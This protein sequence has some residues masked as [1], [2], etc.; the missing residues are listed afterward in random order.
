MFGAFAGGG[1]N[2]L[3]D[4]RGVLV[5]G[6]LL[7]RPRL[8]EHPHPMHGFRCGMLAPS[9]SGSTAW[10]SLAVR[11]VVA[12]ATARGLAEAYMCGQ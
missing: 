7:E 11:I 6:R 3:I 4:A 9:A 10:E 8:R 12:K 1:K 2:S 5:K